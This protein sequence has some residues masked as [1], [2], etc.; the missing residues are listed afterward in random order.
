[1]L[2][3]I[4]R[5]RNKCEVGLTPSDDGMVPSDHAA[6]GCCSFFVFEQTCIQGNASKST[7]FKSTLINGRKSGEVSQ[8]TQSHFLCFSWT[9][10]H[11]SLVFSSFKAADWAVILQLSRTPP[12]DRL[13]LTTQSNQPDAGGVTSGQTLKKKKKRIV[14]PDSCASNILFKFKLEADQ[15]WMQHQHQEGCEKGIK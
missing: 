8:Q 9:Y 1:M 6:S 12:S 7:E 10:F 14:K 3:S 15:H 11:L 2:T 4:S 13:L 5:K